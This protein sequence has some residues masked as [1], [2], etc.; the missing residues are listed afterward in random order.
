MTLILG[1]KQKRKLKRVLAVM[2]LLLMSLYMC[3]IPAFADVTDA[4]LAPSVIVEDGAADNSETIETGVS[5]EEYL[6]IDSETKELLKD[7]LSSMLGDIDLIRTNYVFLGEEVLIPVKTNTHSMRVE[8][9]VHNFEL[10]PADTE[11]LV[12]FLEVGESSVGYREYLE[13]R[14]SASSG[15]SLALISSDGAATPVTALDDTDTVKLSDGEYVSYF[16]IADIRKGT[17]AYHNDGD[18]VIF[19]V[20][21][22]EDSLRIHSVSTLTDSSSYTMVRAMNG[23]SE[24]LPVKTELTAVQGPEEITVYEYRSENGGIVIDSLDSSELSIVYREKDFEVTTGDGIDE[25]EANLILARIDDHDYFKG[26]ID[27]ELSTS[28][29]LRDSFVFINPSEQYTYFATAGEMTEEHYVRVFDG[30]KTI[31]STVFDAYDP[32]NLLGQ[33]LKDLTIAGEALFILIPALQD[34]NN[35]AD[36]SIEGSTNGESSAIISFVKGEGLNAVSEKH[37]SDGSPVATPSVAVKTEPGPSISSGNSFKLGLNKHELRSLSYCAVDKEGFIT[38]VFN[39][40]GEIMG[41]AE[42][43]GISDIASYVLIPACTDSTLTIRRVD[44]T[45]S[46]SVKNHVIEKNL[47][48]ADVRLYGEEAGK[49]ILSGTALLGSLDTLDVTVLLENGTGTVKLMVP[50]ESVQFIASASGSLKLEVKEYGLE[51]G[52][53]AEPSKDTTPE[54]PE[55]EPETPAPAPGPGSAIGGTVEPEGGKDT[56]DDG[57]D[58]GDTEAASPETEPDSN[59]GPETEPET[60]PSNEPETQE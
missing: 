6:T 30:V 8:S 38:A 31:E 60:E 25:Y 20:G 4:S 33:E 23:E 50:L 26:F 46:D 2:L 45:M 5:R 24:Y 14:F 59:A 47:P 29:L 40:D 18:T 49:L 12:G 3:Y 11:L 22:T 58:E 52:L 54:V 34:V 55:T 28:M 9:F 36:L 35:V 27:D 56:E 7:E 32:V 48:E 19:K 10:N 51:E 15:D 42:G 53:P 43:A 16:R 1:R 41:L 57:D 21:A 13:V 44:V 37:A 39:E 17:Y